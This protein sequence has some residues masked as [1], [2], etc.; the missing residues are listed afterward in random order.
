MFERTTPSPASPVPQGG[1][2][3]LNPI[4]ISKLPKVTLRR[5]WNVARLAA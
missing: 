3:R 2:G 1:E 5:P 4:R